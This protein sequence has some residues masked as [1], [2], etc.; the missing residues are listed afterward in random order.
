MASREA[1]AL[2]RILSKATISRR[3]FT[4]VELTVVVVV[5]AMFAAMVVPRMTAMRES[6]RQRA[7]LEGMRRIAVEA[8]EAAV[9][10]RTPTAL[11]FDENAGRFEVVRVGESDERER[12]LRSLTL[13]RDAQ[14]TE[15]RVESRTLTGAEWQL[16]FFPDGRSEGGGLEIELGNRPIAIHVAPSGVV[17]WIEGRLPPADQERWPAGDLEH[18]M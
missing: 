2:P 6:Q 15:L 9:A 8:R 10:E 13:V 7:F 18:R 11:T 17:R 12:A 4:L 14:V 3:A 16:R 1:K 5:L